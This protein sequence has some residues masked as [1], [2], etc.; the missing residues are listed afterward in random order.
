VLPTASVAAMLDWVN[1]LA[2]TPVHVADNIDSHTRTHVHGA[3]YRLLSAVVRHRPETV[4]DSVPALAHA[5]QGTRTP[6]ALGV[7]P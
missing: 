3:L 6:Y 1:G 7:W 5:V 4:A 2:A